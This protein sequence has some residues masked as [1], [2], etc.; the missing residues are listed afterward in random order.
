MSGSNN[1]EAAI[2]LS[3]ILC[4]LGKHQ[5]NLSLLSKEAEARGGCTWAWLRQGVHHMTTDQSADIKQM[6]GYHQD[7]INDYETLLQS[8][9]EYLPALRGLGETSL[10]LAEVHLQQ[11]VD[12][13]VLDCI[14]KSMSALTRA[15]VIRPG[16]A[17][18]WRLLGEAASLVSHLPESV[19]SVRVPVVLVRTEAGPGQCDHLARPRPG[20]GQPQS[21]GHCCFV[22]E[23]GDQFE[24]SPISMLG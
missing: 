9:P 20:P 23:E 21:A 16:M 3:D 12:K 17:G 1:V 24:S 7:A 22:P 8:A 6:L 11:F 5:E 13:N 15:A 18:T 10:A 14:E 4:R 2:S 19:V